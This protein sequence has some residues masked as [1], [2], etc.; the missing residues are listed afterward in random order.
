MM[1]KPRKIRTLI[2]KEKLL[3]MNKIFAEF[4]NNQSESKKNMSLKEIASIL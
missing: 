2:T 1:K 4:A 3:R